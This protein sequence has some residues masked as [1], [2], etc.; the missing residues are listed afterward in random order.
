[1]TDLR[2]IRIQAL[3]GYIQTYLKWKVKGA[4][5]SGNTITPEITKRYEEVCQMFRDEG[6]KFP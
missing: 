2:E 5:A 6:E 3:K 1:M 4:D